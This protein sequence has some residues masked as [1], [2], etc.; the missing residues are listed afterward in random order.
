MFGFQQNMIGS[1]GSGI[2]VIVSSVAYSPSLHFAFNQKRTNVA[3]WV[4]YGGLF[5]WFS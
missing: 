3:K 1:D 5:G 4:E 2:V